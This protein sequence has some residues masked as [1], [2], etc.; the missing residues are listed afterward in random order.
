MGKNLIFYFSGTGNNL[1][2]AKTISENISNAEIIPMGSSHIYE[3][4]G[5][6]ESIGFVYPVY[7]AGLPAKVADYIS[8]LIL[9][10]DKDIYYYK[11]ITFGS[12]IVN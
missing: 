9:P 2:V 5:S 11:L 1:K 8:K 6:Y 12:I 7:F 3:F 4:E 10:E